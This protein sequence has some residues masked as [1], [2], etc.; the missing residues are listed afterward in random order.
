MA[1]TLQIVLNPPR[2]R[3]GREDI[4]QFGLLVSLLKKLT[5]Q[6]YGL[7]VHAALHLY[8]PAAV[9]RWLRNCCLA[10]IR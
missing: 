7:A 2:K 6:V 3:F 10:Q 8:S 1:N 4:K 5:N 9:L